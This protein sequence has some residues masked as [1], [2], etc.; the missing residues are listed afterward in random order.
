MCDLIKMYQYRHL[1]VKLLIYRLWRRALKARE[2]A[3]SST[4]GSGEGSGI[5]GAALELG[6]GGGQAWQGV[7]GR[8]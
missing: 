7:H 3:S 2:A 1:V 6:E 8:R 5:A 4:K